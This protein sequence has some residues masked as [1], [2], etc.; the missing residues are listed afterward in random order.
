MPGK[1]D[2]NKETHHDQCSGRNLPPLFHGQSVRVLDKARRIWHPGTI[3]EKCKKATWFKH[4]METQSDLP[5]VIF[6]RCVRHKHSLSRNECNLAKHLKEMWLNKDTRKQSKIKSLNLLKQKDMI[7]TMRQQY[8]Y[9]QGLDELSLSQCNISTM[10]R[11]GGI[12]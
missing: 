1:K 10:C 3:V 6:V 2:N 8:Q 5:G 9:A 12:A 7:Q 4:R 11:A